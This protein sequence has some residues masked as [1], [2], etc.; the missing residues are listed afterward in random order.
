[1]V[2]FT[3]ALPADHPFAQVRVDPVTGWVVT[4]ARSPL[5]APVTENGVPVGEAVTSV[6]WTAQRGTAVGPGGYAEFLLTVGPIPVVD[7]FQFPATQI[8]DNGTVIDWHDPPVLAGQPSLH[9]VRTVVVAGAAGSAPHDRFQWAGNR[10]AGARRRR[11]G[12]GDCA[13]AAD[14][15]AGRVDTQ[16]RSRVRLTGDQSDCPARC[17]S[18]CS[19]Y[20][21]L[22]G[23]LDTGSER[24]GVQSSPTGQP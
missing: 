11:G 6:T 17:V 9:P 21:T 2:G 16:G 13:A 20:S 1:M 8:C 15:H 24:H 7:S 18:D 10:C 19:G 12:R 14:D 23:L 3:L 4:S 5:P 22:L